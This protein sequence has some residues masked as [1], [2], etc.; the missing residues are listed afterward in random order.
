MPFQL[1][2]KKIE[3]KIHQTIKFCIIDYQEYK[4]H[5]LKHFIYTHKHTQTQKKEG[6][7]VEQN[8]R[9]A[10]R[11]KIRK[12]GDETNGLCQERDEAYKSLNRFVTIKEMIKS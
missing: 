9:T 1:Q 2:N 7:Q 6:I 3:S 8:Q 4:D 11:R 10:G 5:K 12:S